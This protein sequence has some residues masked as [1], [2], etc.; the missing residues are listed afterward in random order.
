MIEQTFVILKPD[1]VHRGLIG[2]IVSRFERCGIK[3][4]ATK[5]VYPD[6]T[7]IGEHYAADDEWLNSVGEKQIASYKKKGIEIT[8]EPKKLGL[9]VRNNLVDFLRL[10]P[11]IAFVLEA[12]NAVAHVRKLVGETSPEASAPGTI[13]GDFS[14]DTYELADKLGR[15]VQNLIHASSSVEEA[16]RE[17]DLWFKSEEIHSWKRVDEEL[18]YRVNK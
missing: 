1:A 3:I 5:M 12:H 11:S 17:I 2:E 16:K 10:S 13:R 4:V 6:E 18:L 8:D 7:T 14:F 9:K 15:A